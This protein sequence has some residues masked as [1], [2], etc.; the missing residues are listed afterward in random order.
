VLVSS[1]PAIPIPILESIR[2]EEFFK[3][4]GIGIENRNFYLALGIG[5]GIDRQAIDS[6]FPKIREKIA[7]Y[8]TRDKGTLNLSIM[9]H[10]K[11][12]L[13]NF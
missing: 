4:N 7:H 2:K 1:V 3:W 8:A 9:E 12:Y 10:K 11:I 5:I 6:Y 13:R